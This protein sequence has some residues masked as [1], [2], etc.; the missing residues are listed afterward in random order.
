MPDRKKNEDELNKIIEAWTVDYTSEH[1]MKIL[2]SAGIPA[3]FWH[4]N[5][6]LNECPALRERG[7]F[8]MQPHTEAG[9][10]SCPSPPFKLSK[11][12]YTPGQVPLA[13][14][15][16]FYICTELLG[17]SAEEYAELEGEGIFQIQSASSR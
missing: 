13:G 8:Q 2:Q 16:S 4:N 1:V 5:K 9:D 11:I 6:D 10:W 17:I 3:G 12:P 7:F 15:D 14:Q